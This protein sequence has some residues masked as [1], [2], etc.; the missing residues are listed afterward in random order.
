MEYRA[1]ES[2]PE[3]IT[4]LTT[5]ADG[6]RSNLQPERPVISITNDLKLQLIM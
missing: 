2:L 5:E 6:V 4:Q 1:N 3:I